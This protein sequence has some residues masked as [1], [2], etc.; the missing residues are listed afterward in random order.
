MIS[1]DFSNA[2]IKD[3][4]TNYLLMILCTLQPHLLDTLYSTKTKNI[5]IP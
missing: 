3:V 1:K 4:I 2:L 5:W